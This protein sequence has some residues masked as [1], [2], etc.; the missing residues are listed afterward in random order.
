[1]FGR[2][3]GLQRIAFRYSNKAIV[4]PQG[5]VIPVNPQPGQ[6]GTLGYTTVSGPEH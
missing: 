4:D 5:N 1:M 6:L 2:S 3:D